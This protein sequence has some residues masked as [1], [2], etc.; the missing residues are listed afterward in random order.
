MIDLF[1]PFVNRTGDE[2]C[3]FGNTCKS[4]SIDK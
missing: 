3:N 2:K 4:G 1:L